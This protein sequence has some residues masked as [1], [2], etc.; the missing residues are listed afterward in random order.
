MC[1]LSGGV[2]DVIEVVPFEMMSQDED[3]LDYITESNN[4]IA[5]QQIIALRKIQLFCAEPG[6]FIVLAFIASTGMGRPGF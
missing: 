5:M 1:A 2:D 6:A 4:N 3:F